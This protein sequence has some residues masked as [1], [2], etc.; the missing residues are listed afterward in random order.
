MH[1]ILSL[2]EIYDKEIKLNNFAEI[3]ILDNF[4]L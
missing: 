3:Y 2:P 4:N 1:V